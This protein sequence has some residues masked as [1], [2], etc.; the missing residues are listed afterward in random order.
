MKDNIESLISKIEYKSTFIDLTK[1][2]D[3]ESKIISLQSD[4]E[5]L[6]NIFSE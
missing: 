4:I 1:L 5:E 2:K 3:V 6:K